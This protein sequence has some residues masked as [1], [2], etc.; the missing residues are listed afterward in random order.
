[1]IKIE[2][3]G[4]DA[5]YEIFETTNA[6]GVD[7]SIADLLKNLIFKHIRAQDD[8]DEAKET[9]AEIVSNVQNT[10]TEMRKF[11]RY[12]W[13]SK[14]PPVTEKNLFRDIKRK[15][16]NWNALLQDLRIA[17]NHF[18]QLI[19]GAKEDWSNMRHGDKIFQSIEA[20]RF[21]NVSQCYVL[22]LSILRNLNKL[23]SDPTRLFEI[24]EKFTFV[25]SVVC[26][27]PGNKVEKL[28]S[29]HARAIE[30]AIT[31]RSEKKI[32]ASISRVFSQLV[33]DLKQEVPSYEVFKEKFAVVS[34]VDSSIKR[35]LISY[36]L[37]KLNAIGQTGEH[38][39]DFDNVNIEHLLP[40]NPS[41]WGLTKAEVKPYVDLL[42]NL[43]L[44]AEKFNS[45]IGNSP[46]D[47]KL[48]LLSESEIRITQEL[49]G[50]VRSNSN[51]WNVD[52]IML[53]QTRFGD[54]AYHRIWQI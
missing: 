16:T 46:L 28:Y 3:T 23:G 18:S 27:Q 1:M 22:F 52:S 37:S 49:V 12:Y 41:R 47:E 53:R 32:H 54:T 15:I 8:R 2:I 34:Y 4:E 6:R 43:T 21:M 36:I 44:L 9:W 24:I 13:L 51:T 5:A 7:L 42:G 20:I 17:S 40:R 45:S 10:K 39:I 26:K 25:Y 38:R 19:E 30:Q 14:Y 35:R 50:L 48:K 11:I 29:K 31:E 33:N